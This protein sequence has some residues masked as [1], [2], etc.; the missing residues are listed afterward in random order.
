MDLEFLPLAYFQ[1]TRTLLEFSRFSR[2]NC[3]SST[4]KTQENEV[5]TRVE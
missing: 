1:Q 4:R 3:G 5:E 2:S